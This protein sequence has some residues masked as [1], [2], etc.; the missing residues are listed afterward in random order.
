MFDQTAQQLQTHFIPASAK[1]QWH[2]TKTMLVFHGQGDCKESYISLIK[3]INLTGLNAL[4]ID[5]PFSAFIAPGFRGNFWYHPDP[6]EQMKTLNYSLE[7]VDILISEHRPEDLILFGFSAGARIVLNLI[8][9]HPDAFAAAVALSP[10]FKL[11]DPL[12]Q[13]QKTPSFISHGK[14]DEVIPFGETQAAAQEWFAFNP[15][16]F[17]AYECGHEIIIDEIQDVREWLS[18]Y[19]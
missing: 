18:N 5:G 9:R 2:Q 16:Q 6:Q 12:N 17:K 8:N 1:G 13:Q 4:L 3:E 19:F 11:I 10:R 14:N 7:L 15:G